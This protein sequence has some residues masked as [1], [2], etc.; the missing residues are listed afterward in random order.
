MEEVTKTMQANGGYI[1]S[2]MAKHIGRGF[3]YNLL[4]MSESGEVVKVKCGLYAL[5]HALA[6]T[7][8][9]IDKLVPDGIICLYSAWYYYELTTQIP[10]AYCVAIDSKRK[11]TLPDYPPIDL[12]YWSAKTLN[13]GVKTANING[14]EVKI[15]DLERSVCDAIRFRNKIGIHVCGEILRNYLK[16]KDSNIPKLMAYGRQ[17]RISQTLNKYLE[18]QVCQ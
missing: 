11:A 14:F 9:D 2:A 12:F 7:M 3:Y 13:V 17:L 5:P 1:S 10:N 16:R 15:Y 18:I 6:N 4:S 8:A